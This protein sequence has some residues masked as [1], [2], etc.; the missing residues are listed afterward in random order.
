MILRYR[1][2]MS[3]KYALYVTYVSKMTF[4]RQYHEMLL[5]MYGSRV[6]PISYTIL[7]K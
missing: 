6:G 5:C 4:K 2:K 1:C 3:Y 7:A